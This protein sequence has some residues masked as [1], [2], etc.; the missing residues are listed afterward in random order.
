MVVD[1]VHD[2][3]CRV[4]IRDGAIGRVRRHAARNARSGAFVPLNRRHCAKGHVTLIR[5][6]RFETVAI[7]ELEP[8]EA[9]PVLRHYLTEVPFTR[10]FLDVTAA[11]SLEAF[12]AEAPRHPVFRILAS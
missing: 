6:G 2:P 1:T 9:A 12:A 3:P 4:S 5:G 10:P 8:H 7:L 11:S